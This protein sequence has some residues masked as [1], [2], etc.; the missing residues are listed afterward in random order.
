MATTLFNLHRSSPAQRS[1]GC[2]LLSPPDSD[3]RRTKH[4]A[5]HPPGYQYPPS[6]DLS[7]VLMV[8]NC[9]VKHCETRGRHLTTTRRAS[10]P[11]RGDSRFAAEIG[12]RRAIRPSITTAGVRHRHG[13]VRLELATI[14]GVQHPSTRC[15][16]GKSRRDQRIYGQAGR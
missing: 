10:R 2:L 1:S 14:Y 16:H 7:S 13:R 11:G 8:T 12:H 5:A 3:C 6:L 9:R 4:T 15:R